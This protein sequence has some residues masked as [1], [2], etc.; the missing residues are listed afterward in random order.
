MREGHHQ[1]TNGGLMAA[2]IQMRGT[3]HCGDRAMCAP[4][5]DAV[6]AALER[7]MHGFYRA[8]PLIL[9]A[10]GVRLNYTGY[11]QSMGG[12]GLIVSFGE[13]MPMRLGRRSVRV[14]GPFG[15]APRRK[16]PPQ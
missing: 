13:V 9:D 1:T 5:I 2:T 7:V 4:V 6:V 8:R 10:W 15:L 12:N 3:R 11:A 14:G 16:C